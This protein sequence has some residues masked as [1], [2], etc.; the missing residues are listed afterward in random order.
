[1]EYAC[2]VEG[3]DAKRKS[4]IGREGK[5]TADAEQVVKLMVKVK[6]GDVVWG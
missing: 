3:A 4:R 6:V 2:W 1:M 5:G